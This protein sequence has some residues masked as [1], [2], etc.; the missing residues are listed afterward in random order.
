[1]VQACAVTT[2]GDGILYYTDPL[3][4]FTKPSFDYTGLGVLEQDFY[5]SFFV[6]LILFSRY[7]H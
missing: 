3:F 6:K 1:M 7:S 2:M 5:K 4:S